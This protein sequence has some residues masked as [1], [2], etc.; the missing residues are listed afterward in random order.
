MKKI[1]ITLILLLIVGGIA[2]ALFNNK[3][4]MNVKAEEA[5]KTTDFIPVRTQTV[6]TSLHQ[7]SFSA[8]GT[9]KANQELYLKSE[10]GGKVLKI[11]K[12]KGD[13]VKEGQMIA[14]LDDELLQSELAISSLTYEQS[15]KDLERYKNMAGTD[16]ITK[17]QL[18]EIQN[19]SK[20]A[21]AQL[22]MI[23]KRISLAKITAP[24]SG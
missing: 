6:G 10:A 1:I 18:E 24:I 16:A 11:F 19:G 14:H 7:I 2:F 22:N 13:F 20:T 23:K 15:L 21:E 12:R 17:K 4:E 3:Q 8:N 9:F 5:M